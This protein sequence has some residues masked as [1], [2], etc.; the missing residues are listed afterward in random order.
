[1]NQNLSILER[2]SSPTP[3]LFKRIGNVGVAIGSI[4]TGIIALPSMGVVL[5]AFVITFAGYCIAAGVVAKGVASLTVDYSAKE[6][7][8]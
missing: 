6:E 3:K 7:A 1:M 8:A 4:G 5:P 2:L